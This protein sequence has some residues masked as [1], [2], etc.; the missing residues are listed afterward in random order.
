[1]ILKVGPSQAAAP[2]GVDPAVP[3]GWV[4]LAGNITK[5]GTSLLSRN[6]RAS[7]PIVSGRRRWQELSVIFGALWRR[8]VIA[9]WRI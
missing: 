2:E 1:M 7:K 9:I 3:D 5:V 8:S 4:P 6:L